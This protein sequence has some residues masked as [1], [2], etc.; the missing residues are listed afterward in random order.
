VGSLVTALFREHGLDLPRRRVF[1]T[2]VQLNNA[3]L[4]TGRYLAFYPGSVIRLSGARLSIKALNLDMPA[5]S[6]PLG[7]I[8]LKGRTPT[9]VTRLFVDGVRDV[10]KPLAAGRRRLRSTGS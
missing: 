2:S 3:L 1:G 5:R 9:P 6:T 8:T 4:A 7:I 10:M